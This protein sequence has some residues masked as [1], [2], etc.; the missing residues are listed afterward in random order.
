MKK[1]SFWYLLAIIMFIPA[2]IGVFFSKTFIGNM[3]V[4]ISLSVITIIVSFFAVLERGADTKIVI[5]ADTI[6]ILLIAA[7]TAKYFFRRADI[8]FYLCILLLAFV[9]VYCLIESRKQKKR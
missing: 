8:G 4:C 2:I 7:I 3:L 6:T 1:I 5:L 9:I